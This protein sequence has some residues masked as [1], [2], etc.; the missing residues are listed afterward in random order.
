[1]DNGNGVESKLKPMSMLKL[2]AA[3]LA[4]G[5]LIAVIVRQHV[6]ISLLAALLITGGVYL[7]ELGVVSQFADFLVMFPSWRE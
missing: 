3:F 2:R 6:A 7:A 4:I 1:M 5:F